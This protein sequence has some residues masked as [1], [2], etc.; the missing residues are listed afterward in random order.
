MEGRLINFYPE[1]GVISTSTI[2]ITFPWPTCG[3]R[4]INDSK[5]KDLEFKFRREENWATLKP[6]DSFLIS[7][8]THTMM[9][10]SPSNNDV[11]YRVWGFGGEHRK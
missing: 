4:I 7:Y 1:E 8:R 9:L 6:K 5:K 10:N 11:A 2:T 3:I